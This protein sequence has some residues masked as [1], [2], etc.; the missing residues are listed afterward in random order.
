MVN[1][2]DKLKKGTYSRAFA[3]G[4]IEILVH[5]LLCLSLPVYSQPAALFWHRD[6]SLQS[7]SRDIGATS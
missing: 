2:G 5:T 4:L 1:G 3:L 7:L 6:G